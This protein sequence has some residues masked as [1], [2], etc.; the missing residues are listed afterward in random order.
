MTMPT[1]VSPEEWTAAR[2]ALLVEEKELTR[3][4]DKETRLRRAPR[5]CARRG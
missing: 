5:R 2:E 3:A 1:I 4:R